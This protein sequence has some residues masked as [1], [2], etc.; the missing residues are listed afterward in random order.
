MQISLQDSP[1]MTITD[2]RLIIGTASQFVAA[3]SSDHGEN[4]FFLLGGHACSSGT[5]GTATAEQDVA[6]FCPLAVR[7]STCCLGIVNAR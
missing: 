4:G 2:K 7:R 6:Q 5:T 3:A 1:L